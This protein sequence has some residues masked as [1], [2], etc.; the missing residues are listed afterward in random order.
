MNLEEYI[1]HKNGKEKDEN[2]ED[3]NNDEEDTVIDKNG[4]KIN[5]LEKI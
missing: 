2:E 5:Q 4:K 1:K 3:E